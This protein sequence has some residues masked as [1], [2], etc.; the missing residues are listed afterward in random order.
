MSVRLPQNVLQGQ[1]GAGAGGEATFLGGA[2][3]AR[4]VVGSSPLARVAEWPQSPWQAACA[5]TSPFALQAPAGEAEELASAEAC[6]LT[7]A[8]VKR[9]GIATVV[10]CV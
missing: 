9:Y 10:V 8:D 1:R 7:G 5:L 4:A 2:L 3:P 6:G